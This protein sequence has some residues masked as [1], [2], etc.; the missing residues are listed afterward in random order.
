MSW[1][2]I[3]KIDDF[4]T[5]EQIEEANRRAEPIEEALLAGIELIG[6]DQIFTPSDIYETYEEMQPFIYSRTLD[7]MFGRVS[8]TVDIE[9]NVT[10]GYFEGGTPL[11]LATARQEN[12]ELL[13]SQEKEFNREPDRSETE[14]GHPR[15]ETPEEWD[16]Y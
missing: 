3:L 6:E 7:V 14:F 1:K 13:A 15:F 5:D 11:T 2:E 12:R 10:L 16:Y 9:G 4:Y 8:I